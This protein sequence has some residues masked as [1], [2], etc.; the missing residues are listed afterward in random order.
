MKLLEKRKAAARL[1]RESGTKGKVRTS[2]S[3]I[4][5][6]GIVICVTVSIDKKENIE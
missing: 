3:E 4:R 6:N 1:Y 2:F 5:A